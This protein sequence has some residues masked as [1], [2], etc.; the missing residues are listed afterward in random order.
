MSNQDALRICLMGHSCRGTH[1]I[2]WVL[3]AFMTFLLIGGA[4]IAADVDFVGV[5]M[6]TPSYTMSVAPLIPGRAEQPFGALNDGFGNLTLLLRP[7]QIGL[8]A[9]FSSGRAHR[10]MR[11]ADLNGDGVPDLVS[12]VYN[13]HANHCGRPNSVSLLFFQ[14]NTSDGA[15]A[16]TFTESPSFRTFSIRG[17]G[18]TIVIADFNN[19]GAL[20]VFIPQYA[21]EAQP[22]CPASP[23]SYLLLND[24]SGNFTDISIQAGVSMPSGSWGQG[25]DP[26][27]G[28]SFDDLFR[29][30]GAQA[31]DFNDDGFIDLYVASHFFINNG[32]LTF[33]NRRAAYGLPLK[34]DEGAKFLDWNNDGRLDL[35]LMDPRY[36]PRLF[37]F[38][39]STFVEKRTTLSG[40]P[41]FSD[42]GRPVDFGVG[43][44]AFGMNVY[45]LD[46][47]GREDVVVMG[48]AGCNNMAFRNTGTG[49]V[50][51]SVG[52]SAFPLTGLGN[53]QGGMA[54]G[55]FNGDGRID[56]AYPTSG[57][58]RSGCAPLSGEAMTVFTNNTN[59]AN[60]FFTV[61]VLGPTGERNQQGR[62][63][64]ATPASRPGTTF[65]RVVDGGSGFMAQNQ[66][67]ILL[68]TPYVESHTVRIHFAKGE[69]EFSIIPG[70]Y[71]RV[72]APLFPRTN[73]EVEIRPPTS[74]IDISNS[75]LLQ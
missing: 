51:A 64:K 35:V 52:S 62:I 33:T 65:T 24:G 60:Q 47:D 17:R 56:M 27:T 49:F 38:N 32:N 70:S 1:R 57:G 8:D 71:A 45:D 34:F 5:P 29:P 26:Q 39:G 50:R 54:F 6:N 46:N 58:S 28:K 15:P 74:L 31:V 37:E 2:L 4:A 13:S 43:K 63:V 48:G 11:V 73:A 22:G 55:D 68:G 9:L 20:D 23:R 7:D 12:N 75:L 66:Y 53:G 21:F 41:F 42:N 44:E 25:I 3:A 69:A 36:G 61:E 59:N 67:P 18:E 72:Y 19:D 14:N 10:D 30:E 16:G 40:A